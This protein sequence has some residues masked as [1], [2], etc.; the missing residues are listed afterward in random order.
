M[1][2]DISSDTDNLPAR[3][4]CPNCIHPI[5]ERDDF[6]PQC[7]AP[8]GLAVTI[9]PFKRIWAMGFLYK[10]AVNSRI[11]G[12]M[13]VGMWLIMLPLI[14]QM[15]NFFIEGM[16]QVLNGRAVF[17]STYSRILYGPAAIV[18]ALLLYK[19]TKNYRQSRVPQLPDEDEDDC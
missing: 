7:S 2:E 10:Q 4:V 6:C 15:T 5:N 11:N 18:P 14:L 17:P 1:A 8:V 3:P 16:S 9:D 19:T 12:F 13:L